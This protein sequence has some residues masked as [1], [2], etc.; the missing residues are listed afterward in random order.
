[1]VSFYE[2][3]EIL[4]LSIGCRNSIFKRYTKR[5]QRKV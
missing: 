1:M 2:Q 5:G 3:V 4:D